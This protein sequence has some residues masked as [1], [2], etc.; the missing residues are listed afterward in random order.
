[1]ARVAAR[2][3]A[4]PGTLLVRVVGF[5]SLPP[6]AF[7]WWWFAYDAHAPRVFIGGTNIAAS[8]GVIAAAVAIVM[9]V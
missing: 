3:P 5:H 9:S 6:P 8:G 1:M 2:L 7:F 4:G